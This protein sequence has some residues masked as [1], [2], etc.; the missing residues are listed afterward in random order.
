[1]VGLIKIKNEC[2][3]F[4][5]KKPN[6]YPLFNYHDLE[7]ISQSTIFWSLVRKI[8]QPFKNVFYT[9][10][11]N[12]C[13]KGTVTFL[14]TLSTTSSRINLRTFLRNRKSYQRR[15]SELVFIA[16]STSFSYLIWVNCYRNSL[17]KYL[18]HV[19]SSVAFLQYSTSFYNQRY[20]EE[21]MHFSFLC[22]FTS[23]WNIHS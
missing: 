13:F 10:F 22:W 6:R 2:L 18:F 1:M 14:Y 7:Y 23:A 3:F 8:S 5:L 20:I 15:C 19:I 9:F 17:H 4:K 12:S 16:T 11:K 21:N